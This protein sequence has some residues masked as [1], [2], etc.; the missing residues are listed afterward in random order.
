MSACLVTLGDSVHWGQGLRRADKLHAIVASELRNMHPDLE[1]HLLAHSG[2]IIG[3]GAIVVRQRVD[4]EVPIPYP[5][6]LQ[7]V[8]G[9]SGDPAEAAVVLV[10]GSINDVDIRNILNPFVPPATLS[11]L[12]L[13]HSYDSMRVLLDAICNRFENAATS[14]VVTTYYPVLSTRSNPVAIPRLL[15]H[16]GLAVPG[17]ID[18]TIRT[19]PIVTRCLQFWHESTDCL[20]RAVNEV[21]DRLPRERIVVADPGFTEN[22]AAFA[23]DPWLF[24]LGS[25]VTWAPQDDVATD[26]RS[27][28]DAAFPPA[29]WPAREQCYRASAGHPNATG[30][31]KY[32][33][34]ILRALR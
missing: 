19:N 24:G 6:I 27:A 1:H 13:E 3:A 7:Q 31:K 17:G 28:C 15:A 9:F 20:K 32:A 11:D 4:G 25:D 14:V 12:I 18:L 8:D 33:A 16:E 29:A 2:A 5:T 22:N 10:N 23:D 21:N 30:A 34:A 26:R